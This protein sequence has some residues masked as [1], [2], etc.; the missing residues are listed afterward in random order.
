M[1]RESILIVI[2]ASLCLLTLNR[3]L[4]SHWQR[5]QDGGDLCPAW[6]YKN[7]YDTLLQLLLRRIASL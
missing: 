5:T 4:L 1:M 3:L 7:D 2:A 6:A